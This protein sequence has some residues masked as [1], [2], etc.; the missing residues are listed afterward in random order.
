[1]YDYSEERENI[2]TDE[3][4]QVFLA[5]RDKANELIE[6]AGCFMMGKVLVAGGSSWLMMACVDRMVELGEIREITK[7]A[8]GQCRVFVPKG[9]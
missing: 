7:H 5:I 9:K 8:P 2:F 1:M 4:Q 6:V 3:G